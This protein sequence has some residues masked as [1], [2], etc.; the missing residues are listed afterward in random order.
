[1][2]SGNVTLHPINS[3]E[4]GKLKACPER[5]KRVE[6]E[7]SLNV[8]EMARDSST[9]LRMTEIARQPCRIICG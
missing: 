2:S 3:G 6:W 4:A 9:S 7:T 8:S 1:M 5:A